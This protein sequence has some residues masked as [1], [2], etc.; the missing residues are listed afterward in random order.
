MEA[1]EPIMTDVLKFEAREIER[2][3]EEIGTKVEIRPDRLH[4]SKL[5][6]ATPAEEEKTEFDVILVDGGGI[7]TGGCIREIRGI[8]GLLV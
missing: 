7:R 3:A 8:T 4:I 5:G 2:K 1:L 6:A